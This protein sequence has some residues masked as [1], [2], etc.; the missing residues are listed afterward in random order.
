[1]LPATVS[2]APETAGSADGF[3]DCG[4]GKYR[5]ICSID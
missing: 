5:Y 4:F 1:M 3:F 2:E